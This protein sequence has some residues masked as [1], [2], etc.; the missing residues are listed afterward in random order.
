MQKAPFCHS[1]RSEESSPTCA[2]ARLS[3][4]RRSFALAQDNNFLF[5]FYHSNTRNYKSGLR[6]SLI[7]A[8]KSNSIVRRQQH[9]LPA[10]IT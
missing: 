5:V 8:V 2:N 10:V 9:Q 3:W 4:R 1:E 7:I 6:V